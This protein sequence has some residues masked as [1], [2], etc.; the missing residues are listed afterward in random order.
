MR[1]QVNLHE[2]E[3]YDKLANVIGISVVRTY[4]TV[5]SATLTKAFEENP[6]FNTLSR[7]TWNRHSPFDA[8]GNM[9]HV[10]LAA[11]SFRY[12][13]KIRSS[14]FNISTQDIVNIL[15]HVA[16]FYIVKAEPEYID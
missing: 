2:F 4:I 15:K 11:A 13:L 9:R 14:E 10:S 7:Y 16:A 8:T 5:D 6:D 1:K 3:R 12:L